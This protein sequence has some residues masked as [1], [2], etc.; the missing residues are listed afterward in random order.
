MYALFYVVLQIVKLGLASFRDAACLAEVVR[1]REEKAVGAVGGD[2]DIGGGHVGFA[3]EDDAHDL[4]EIV[5]AEVDGTIGKDAETEHH[6]NFEACEVVIAIEAERRIVGKRGDLKRM[7]FELW[8]LR[9]DRHGGGVE[10]TV[11]PALYHLV[12]GA[13]RFNLHEEVVKLIAEFLIV[14]FEGCGNIETARQV[15]VGGETEALH[16]E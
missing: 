13:V 16:A 11:A 8:Q 10:R 12:E 5:A 3:V 1:V 15:E 6:L 2:E 7:A 4:V 14:M 9:E